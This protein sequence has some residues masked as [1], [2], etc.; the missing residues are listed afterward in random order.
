MLGD[1]HPNPKTKAWGRGRR[2]VI[3][4]TFS[5]AIAYVDWLSQRTGKSYRLLS[6]AEWEYAARAHTKTKYHFGYA[7]YEICR[8]GNVADLTAMKY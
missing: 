2:S 5:E 8:Y 4:V 6:E 3:N 7:A 1:A